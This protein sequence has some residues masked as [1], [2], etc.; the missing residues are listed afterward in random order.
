M[1]TH[2]SPP[3][4]L[5]AEEAALCKGLTKHRRF[6]RFLRLHRH[7]LFADG[8]EADLLA[9]YSDSPRGTPPKPAALLTLVI[10]LQAFTGA[11]DDD[12]VQNT[13]M[14]RRW[15]LVLDSLGAESALFGRTTLVDFRA[16][17]V[18]A[19]FAEKLLRRTADL[20]RKTRDF[21]PKKVATFRIAIDSLPL[22]GTGRVEDT[23][24]LLA[25]GLRLLVVAIGAAVLLTPDQ[26]YAQ[27]GLHILAS[28][29]PKTGLDRD[30]DEPGSLDAALTDLMREV[31]LLHSWVRAQHPDILRLRLVS[32]AEAQLQKLIKQDTEPCGSG[33]HRVIQDTAP[34]RQL[35]L[36]DPEMRHGRKSE[37][38]RIDG[39]KVYLAQNLDI[40]V[41]MACGVLPA[42]QP[43]KDGADKLGP[44]LK[45][46]GETSEVHIDRA[47]LASQFVQEVASRDLQAVV[48]RGR[49]MPKGPRYGKN[50][51]QIDLVSGR[52]KCPAGKETVIEE[53]D[54]QR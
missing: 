13:F 16:R 1:S 51:F 5:S 29:S 42:N 48:C 41:T 12:A 17:L 10:L 40:D 2:W 36:F 3:V 4:E 15:Q 46:Q 6:F 45:E 27:V 25:R 23:L 20:A 54:G 11:S 21:D 53:T 38:E 43:E 18:K 22:D 30:W 7:S 19:G 37:S 34:D 52:V 24:N 26:L 9:L 39:Y 31:E 14:D 28:K 35:S 8:F 32:D 44:A 33:G 49:R 47:F 50:D